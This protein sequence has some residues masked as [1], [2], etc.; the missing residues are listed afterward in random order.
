[1]KTDI[2]S[3]LIVVNL[4]KR[5]KINFIMKSSVED[6]LKRL[7]YESLDYNDQIVPK[8]FKTPQYPIRVSINYQGDNYLFLVGETYPYNLNTTHFQINGKEV[9]LDSL[10][11][12][13]EFKLQDLIFL[14]PNYW[15][16]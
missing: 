1:M 12:S 7:L 10:N 13:P 2:I 4:N 11:W 15:V 8:I 9:G 5:F 6:T 3:A 16:L 14:C